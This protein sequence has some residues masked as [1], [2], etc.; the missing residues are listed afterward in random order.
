MPLKHNCLTAILLL[1][2]PLIAWSQVSVLTQHNDIGRTGANLAETILTPSTVN[3]NVF[4]KLFTRTVD[5]QLFAQPLY[6]NQV[7]INGTTRNVVYLATEN[8]TVYAFDADDPLASS[9][10]WSAHLGTPGNANALTSG[11]NVTPYVGI[12]STPVIDQQHGW[13]YVVAKTIEPN[14]TYAQR[15]HAL[16]IKTGAEVASIGSPVLIAATVP[17]S[18]DGG[19]T[20]TFNPK[21]QLNRPALLLTG[22]FVY[23]AFGSHADIPPYHGWV[24]RYSASNLASPPVA[25]TVSPNTNKG[26]IWQSG[27]GPASD[28]T[29]V[30][31]A[32]GD[33][34]FDYNTGDGGL[35][36]SILKLSP[37][38]SVADY[39]TPKEQATLLLH[40]TDLGSAG[41]VVLPPLPG[42][43]LNLLVHG[44]KSAALYLMN[45]DNMGHFDSQTDHV[46]QEFYATA[47]GFF[48][49]PVFWTG[50]S[51]SYLYAWGDSDA[52]KQY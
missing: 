51:G 45:R 1:H 9:P 27:N 50:S 38:L 35:G 19:T 12:T 2:V 16:D 48:T 6:V 21:T 46:V 47:N 20:V 4:G 3:V 7:T 33:G 39:F 49:S 5:G 43:S 44:A 30:Y 37:A 23:I 22:G 8:N 42:S 34:T 15:L 26:G 10:L 41:P 24:F 36:D 11:D 18:G 29:N 25:Y 14:N 32:T 52:I 13:L 40:D 28:G 31:L 17:G